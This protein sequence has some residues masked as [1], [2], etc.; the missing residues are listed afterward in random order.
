MKKAKLR[1]MIGKQVRLW[2]IARRIDVTRGELSERDDLWD[3]KSSTHNQVVL[4]NPMTNLTAPLGIDHIV[5][6]QS[7]ADGIHRL[8]LKRQVI[9]KNGQFFTEPITPKK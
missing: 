5:E 4:F 6:V 3:I 1:G 9:D 2:P 8:I 7:E